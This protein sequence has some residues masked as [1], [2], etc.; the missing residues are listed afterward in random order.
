MHV[1]LVIALVIS[2]YTP[3][4]GCQWCTV[5]GCGDVAQLE[6]GGR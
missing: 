3:A 2:D 1:R 4:P 5:A 6:G